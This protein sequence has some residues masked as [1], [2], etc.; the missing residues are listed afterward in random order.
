MNQSVELLLSNPNLLDDINSE[1]SRHEHLEWIQYAWQRTDPLIIGRHTKLICERIDKAIEDFRNGISTKLM[2]KVPFR[3]GKSDIVSRYL[4]P[5]FMGLFPDHDCIV[6]GYSADLAYTFSKFARRLMLSP[7]H[8]K[9]FPGAQLARGDQ[10]VAT[11]GIDGHN[12]AAYWLGLDGSATGKGG[13]LIVVDDF[14]KGR[15][16][17]E[18]ETIREKRWEGFRDNIMT[19]LAPVHIL[20]ILATPWHEDD[21]F[22]RIQS[23]MKNDPRFP[24]FEEIRIPAYDH[25]YG[26]DGWLFPER[27]SKEWYESQ[28]SVLGGENGYSYLSLMQ[29]DPVPRGGTLIKTDGIKIIDDMPKGLQWF[30]AWDLASSEK[31]RQSD[32]PD[33]T[34]GV[35]L[36]VHWKQTAHPDIQI[37]YLFVSDVVRGRWEAPQRND[38]IVQTTLKDGD[39]VTV[40]VEAFG[41]Y[42][43]AYNEL[44]LILRGVVNLFKRNMPGDKLAKMSPLEPIFEAGN[45]YLLK[46]AWN[47]EYIKELS[48]FPSGKHDD[49]CDATAVGYDMAKLFQGTGF[50]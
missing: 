12:G 36:A 23:K 31:Q 1:L 39:S 9:C 28:R 41:P 38:K 17:A 46:A 44:K 3:H 20:I 11:W 8:A 32:D 27:F 35:K 40:G 4:P 30:R 6:T 19:R 42:K 33:Y 34:V 43:D 50:A 25:A 2:I 22:G 15:E 47:E 7:Q 37:P 48:K 21:L 18:S 45:V 10:S 26:G 14:F 29:C 49:Q 5:R 13:S 24:R 16:E